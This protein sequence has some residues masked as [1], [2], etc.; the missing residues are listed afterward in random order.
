MGNPL[1][2][3][4]ILNSPYECP[5]RHWKLDEGGQPTHAIIESRRRAQFIT[6]IPI[7]ETLVPAG[8][9]Q[10]GAPRLEPHG[11][12]PPQPRP[13]RRTSISPRALRNLRA[14]IAP[15]TAWH[16]RKGASLRAT[17]EMPLHSTDSGTDEERHA[18]R[19]GRRPAF[20]LYGTGAALSSAFPAGTLWIV[21]SEL[22]RAFTCSGFTTK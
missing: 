16:D 17:P 6:P 12:R 1:F 8:R 5:R 2:D 7:S 21:Q 22:P 10:G 20:V 18:L 19:S 3:R 13:T 9:K 14:A 11:W 15:E 4:P